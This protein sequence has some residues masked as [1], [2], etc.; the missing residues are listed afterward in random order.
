MSAGGVAVLRRTVANALSLVGAYVAGRGLSFIA[1]VVAARVLGVGEFGAYGTAGAL[2]VT[3]SLVSTLG[4]LPLLVREMTRDPDDAGRWLGAAVRVK[5]GSN[6][7]MLV[8]LGVMAGPVL[9]YRPEVVAAALL[10]GVGYALGSYV[11]NLAAYFQAVERMHVWTGASAL[12]GLVT[13]ISGALIVWLTGSLVAFCAAPVAGQLVSLTWLYGRLPDPVRGVPPRSEQVR[14]LVRSVVPF[15][16]AFLALTLYYKVDV[17][18]LERLRGQE[19]VGVYAAAYR[20]VDMFQAVALAG[21]GAVYPRLSRLAPGAGRSGSWAATRLSELV[22]LAAVPV[23]AGVYL[24]R[25][26]FVL[27]LF[28]AQYRSSVEVL[29]ILAWVLPALAVN[30]YAG[31][32]LAAAGRMRLMAVLYVG[33]LIVNVLLNAALIPGR[34][35]PGAALAMLISEGLLAAGFLTALAGAVNAAPGRKAWW[36]AAGAAGLAWAVHLLP[37]PSAGLLG[38]LAFGVGV[39]LLYRRMDVIEAREIELVQSAFGLREAKDGGDPPEGDVEIGVGGP[40]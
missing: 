40:V 1:V 38:V 37:D 16:A 22:L 18:I 39:V 7:L 24:L 19:D 4:M 2:A 32:V 8:T 23:G 26:P 30:L 9:G 29:G 13:G 27:L 11:E 10:L 35:A 3:L 21:V 15:A 31:Y 20:F 14:E 28:G 12:Y 25:E 33:G 6:L 36:G 34:G 17:L 5:H